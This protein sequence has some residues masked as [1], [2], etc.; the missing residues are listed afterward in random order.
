MLPERIVLS[1]T[2]EHIRKGDVGNPVSCPMALALQVHPSIPKGAMCWVGD[3]HAIV[4]C[5]GEEAV[6]GMDMAGMLFSHVLLDEGKK[7]VG[8]CEVGL[9]KV[10]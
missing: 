7:G 10:K 4:L 2:E 1:V 9:S 6:Y 3:Y 5:E 8:A